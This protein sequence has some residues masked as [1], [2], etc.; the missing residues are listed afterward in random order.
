VK[1]QAILNDAQI[2]PHPPEI[3]NSVT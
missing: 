3:G 1:E 2:H